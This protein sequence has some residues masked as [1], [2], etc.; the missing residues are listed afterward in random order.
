MKII[1]AGTEEEEFCWAL[2]LSRVHFSGAFSQSTPSYTDSPSLHCE[3]SRTSRQLFSERVGCGWYYSTH[4]YVCL[5]LVIHISSSSSQHLTQKPELALMSSFFCFSLPNVGSI[6]PVS[7]QHTLQ[8]SLYTPSS[9][10]VHDHAEM[11]KNLIKKKT[12]LLSPL[13]F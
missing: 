9:F 2:R 12:C 11:Y 13:F 10:D 4:W 5:L 1:K 3:S 8:N 6:G 7:S